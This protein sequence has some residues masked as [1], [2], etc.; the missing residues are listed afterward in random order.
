MKTRNTQK[1]KKSVQGL[2]LNSS[3]KPIH[4][5]SASLITL[6]NYVTYQG[7]KSQLIQKL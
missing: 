5:A 4:I 6:I 2:E 7:H 1:L 3:S